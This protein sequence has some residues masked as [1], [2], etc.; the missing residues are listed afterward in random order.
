MA[1]SLSGASPDVNLFFPCYAEKLPR[2]AE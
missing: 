1:F 2:Y